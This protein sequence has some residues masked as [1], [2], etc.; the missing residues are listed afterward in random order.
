MGFTEPDPRED[1]SG[2]DVARKLLILGRQIG[3]KMDIEEVRVESL[4]PPALRRGKFSDRFFTALARTTRR[5]TGAGRRR[6][7]RGHVLRYVGTVQNGKARAG[8]E[9]VSRRPPAGGDAKGATTSSPSRPSAMPRRR[10]SC[11]APARAPT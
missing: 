7:S 11:R 6:R 3:L 9:G 2:E 4:V 1:L 8:V 5:C 10:W